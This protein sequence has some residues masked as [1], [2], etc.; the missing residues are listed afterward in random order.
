MKSKLI[1]FAFFTVGAAIGVG[2][3]WLYFKK[4]YEDEAKADMDERLNRI[5][6]TYPG[7]FKL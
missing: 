4:K 1:N 3:S 7:D 2:S 5:P 6:E